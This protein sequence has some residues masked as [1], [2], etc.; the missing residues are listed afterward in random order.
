LLTVEGTARAEFGAGG[1]VRIEALT[2]GVGSLRPDRA[3]MERGRGIVEVGGFIEVLEGREEESFVDFARGLMVA[4]LD[5]AE[6]SLTLANRGVDLSPAGLDRTEEGGASR[7]VEGVARGIPAM[8]VEEIDEDNE[9]TLL[10]GS[11]RRAMVADPGTIAV[12]VG[13]RF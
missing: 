3:E 4:E 11:T 8:V 2:E 13:F 5:A 7:E 9:L 10:L 6:C 1:M 12:R